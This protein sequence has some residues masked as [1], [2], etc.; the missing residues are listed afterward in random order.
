MIAETK[1]KQQLALV[2]SL[3]GGG[4]GTAHRFITLRPHLSLITENVA[5][6]EFSRKCAC[7]IRSGALF[8]FFLIQIFFEIVSR[9]WCCLYKQKT[10]KQKFHEHKRIGRARVRIVSFMFSLYHFNALLHRVKTKISA[11]NLMEI[12]IF[13]YSSSN[14]LN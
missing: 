9:L 2:H 8:S 10:C 14:H 1:N 7:R 4:R 11:F 13:A 3:Y 5:N 12:G 6:I